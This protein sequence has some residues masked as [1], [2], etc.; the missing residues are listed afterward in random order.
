MTAWSVSYVGRG[1]M[2]RAAARIIKAMVIGT[3]AKAGL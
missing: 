1:R 3:K 2:V